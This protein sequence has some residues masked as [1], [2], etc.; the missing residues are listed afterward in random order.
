M[1]SFEAL[2]VSIA[3]GATA[4]ITNRLKT[5]PTKWIVVKNS[6]GMGISDNAMSGWN[7]DQVTL[8]NVGASTTVISVIFFR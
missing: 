4:N 1:E 6:T 8:K 5:I 3:S 7:Q 2:N